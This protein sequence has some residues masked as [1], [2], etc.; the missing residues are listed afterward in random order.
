MHFSSNSSTYRSIFGNATRTSSSPYL[1]STTL[2]SSSSTTL[3]SS[4]STTFYSSLVT[5]SSSSAVPSSSVAI[6]V[7]TGATDGTGSADTS[8]GETTAAVAPAASSTDTS[9]DSASGPST[10]TLVGG[11]VGGVAGLALLVLAAL[12]F[13][14][15]KRRMQ[16]QSHKLLGAGGVGAA[17]GATRGL[18]EGG[19]GAGSGGGISPGGLSPGGISPGGVSPGGA[20]GDGAMAERRTTFLMPFSSFASKR[21]SRGTA[22]TSSDGESGF[23]R[24]SGKKLPSVLMYGGDG[25]QDPR[26]SVQSGSSVVF[27]DSQGFFGGEGGPATVPASWYAV[28]T[29]MRP[30]S[31]VPVFQP[32]FGKTAM[33]MRVPISQ[34]GSVMLDN[35]AMSPNSPNGLVPP[36]GL[37]PAGRSLSSRES[38]GSGSRFTEE[39]L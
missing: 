22:G 21:L 7:I 5:L 34:H 10:S 15:W 39:I 20:G 2:Y 30:E 37:D 33:A 14:R 26:E 12:M 6:A 24:V 29:P 31:G 17:A 8:A 18:I 16:A 1:S 36:T 3:Y 19:K 35:E 32:G 25:Y 28:G 13:L 4:S 27:R 23:Y 11:V 9:S 38:R